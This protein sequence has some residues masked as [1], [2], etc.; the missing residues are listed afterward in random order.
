LLKSTPLI[1]SKTVTPSSVNELKTIVTE[2]I[3][4][5]KTLIPIGGGTQLF[6]AREKF[7]IAIN[8]SGLTKGFRHTPEDMTATLPAGKLFS[9]AQNKLK[10]NGQ[11]IPLDPPDNGLSTVGG[12]VSANR[13]GPRRHRYGTVRDWVIATTIIN[14]KGELVKSGA[15]VVKNVSGYDLNK[16]YI[17]ARGTLGILVDITF[18]LFPTHKNEMTFHA[19]F[20]NLDEIFKTAS[21]INNSPLEIEALLILNGRWVSSKAKHWWLLIKIIGSN[22]SMESQS[23]IV[24]SIL[25]NSIS[26]RWRQTNNEDSISYWRTAN[27]GNKNSKELFAE[28]VITIPK[29]KTENLVTQ[30]FEIDPNISMKILPAC[31]ALTIGLNSENIYNK[32]KEIIINQNINVEISGKNIFSCNDKWPLNPVSLPLMKQLKKAL[33]PSYIFAPRT[34]LGRI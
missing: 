18:K 15:N 1:A 3:E 20:S 26:K 31:G 17:G 12:I 11:W 24:S 2:A 4:N 21:E 7:D 16:V 34:Y 6:T 27:L 9:D 30:I 19:C 32:F 5:K 10:E 8:I 14:G 25:E 23:R 33:D 29:S 13:W 28:A 22:E